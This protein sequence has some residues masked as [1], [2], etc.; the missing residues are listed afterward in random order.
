VTTDAAQRFRVERFHAPSRSF[1]TLGE[2][3]SVR[4]ALECVRYQR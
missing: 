4:E 1:R 3:W 2:F